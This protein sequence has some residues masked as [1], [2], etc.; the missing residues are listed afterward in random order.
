MANKHLSLE[1]FRASQNSLGKLTENRIFKTFFQ[2]VLLNACFLFLSL[3]FLKYISHYLMQF[4]RKSE[5]QKLTWRINLLKGKEG[6]DLNLLLR[7]VIP[8]SVD[9]AVGYL[10][11]AINIEIP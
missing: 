10:D 5:F 11:Y 2:P 6:W 7:A 9:V 1:E 4:V 8:M 3:F